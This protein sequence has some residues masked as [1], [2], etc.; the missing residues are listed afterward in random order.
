MA[1]SKDDD[2]LYLFTGTSEVFI[3]NR[4]SRILQSITKETYT[5]IRYDCESTSLGK[6][7]NECITIPL[8]ED[9]KV[10]IL[11]NP[12]FLSS[13][14]D[15]LT[16]DA[17]SFIK[18]LKNPAESC[19]L[20][21]DAHGTKINPTN[22]IYKALKNYALIINYDD[23]QEIELKGWVIRSFATANVTIS[24]EA[25]NLFM[26]Y[27]NND[28]IRMEQEINKLINY[29]GRGKSVTTA[30]IELLVDKDLS[31]EIFNLI[32][33]I[34]EH[35]HKRIAK[36]YQN[37]TQN[38]KDASNILGMINS[39]FVDMVTIAK[40][41]KVGYSQNDIAKAYNVSPGRAYYM[42]KNAK[43]FKLSDLENYVIKLSL[44]D[45][46]IK[47]GQIDKSLGMDLLIMEL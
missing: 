22:E 12:T 19:I 41:L 38:T 16:S 14:K 3:K 46:K 28:Q 13:T 24:E 30:D 29:V 10:V 36:I 27:L 9:I 32:K 11:K 40:L 6:I 47:S 4:I 5:I 2:L 8:L 33:A 18:Y 1:L 7:I 44:L 15:T 25:I 35:N 37:L 31:N 21:I 26:D 39:S 45:Y 17:K 34:V 43:S 20:M 42:V 23:S